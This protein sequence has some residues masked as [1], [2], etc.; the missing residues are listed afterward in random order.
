[1]RKDEQ[2][3]KIDI[4]IPHTRYHVEARRSGTMVIKDR[5]THIYSTVESRWLLA[6]FSNPLSRVSV[7][8]RTVSDD[9]DLGTP[10]LL[11]PST[12]AASSSSAPATHW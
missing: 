6:L 11:P 9:S 1:M 5:E 2:G 4:V 8:S 7:V 10:Y 3:V 12:P